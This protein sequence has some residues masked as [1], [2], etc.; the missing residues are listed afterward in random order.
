[1]IDIVLTEC[2]Y[3]QQV[4]QDVLFRAITMP[5]M[6]QQ[7]RRPSSRRIAQLANAFEIVHRFGLYRFLTNPC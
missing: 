7:T 3:Y 4:T 2:Q 5:S 6:I 1:M